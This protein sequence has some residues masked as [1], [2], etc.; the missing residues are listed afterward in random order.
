MK[1]A[2]S[3]MFIVVFVSTVVGNLRSAER[4][5]KKEDPVKVVQGYLRAVYAR[6]YIEAYR[7]ISAADQRVKDV[8]RYAQQRGAFIGF[9]LEATRKLANFM[10]IR[11]VTK[12]VGPNR[13]Q[14]VVKIRIPE[15]NKI[16]SLMLNW[17]LRQLN[18]L[19]MRDRSHI[20]ESLEKRR[21]E[22]SLEMIEV[23]ERLELVK[24]AD[25]WRIFL[26][27]AAGVRIPL[28]LALPNASELDVALSITEVVVQP[29][30]LFEIS[31]RIRNRSEHGVNARIDHVIEPRE[32]ANYLDFVECGFLIPVTLHPQKE[33]EYLA[34][35]LL[36]ESLPEG[37]RQLSL[38]YDFKLRRLLR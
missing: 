2:S 34:R 18:S 13:I 23:D 3:V 26:D 31:L 12:P 15:P 33:Q 30:D 19:E 32:I 20:I 38:T 10:E 29:G 4:N 16:S 11:P 27:W 35:Y 36:R 37:I 17:D 7:Y 1:L 14:A 6:D 21:Q 28:R 9:A 5:P 8:N 24:E 22:R 25:E